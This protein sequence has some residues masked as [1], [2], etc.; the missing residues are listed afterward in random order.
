MEQKDR[1]EELLESLWIITVEGQKDKSDFGLLKDDEAVKDLIKRGYVY[2]T[3]NQLGLTDVGKAEAQKC[4]RRH[5][6]AERLMTDVFV[7]KSELIHETSCKFEHLIHRDLEKSICTLLGHPKTCPHGKPIPPGSCCRGASKD[8][9]KRIIMPLAELEVK[10]KGKVA[11]LQ[12]GNRDVLQKMI[13]M[14]VL[15]KTEILLLQKFPSY[16]IQIGKSQF[17]LDK[18]MASQIYV[19]QV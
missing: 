15:P 6:L 18:E 7:E 2:I 5:R 17:A 19:R 12:T 13:A 1:V 4:I 9:L 3:E 16:V 8:Y 14:G 11:Y 10:R